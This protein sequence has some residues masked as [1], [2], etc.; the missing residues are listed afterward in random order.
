MK[1]RAYF[2]RGL[3]A[4]LILCVGLVPVMAG[5]DAPAHTHVWREDWA[6]LLYTS[7]AADDRR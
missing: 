7:D 6:C 4:A 1:K 2:G 5:A 3:A